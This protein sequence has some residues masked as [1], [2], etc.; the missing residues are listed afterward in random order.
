MGAKWPYFAKITPQKEMLPA[1]PHEKTH[2]H[3]QT[4]E[5]AEL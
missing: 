3:P 2:K 5:T 4:Q 1:K